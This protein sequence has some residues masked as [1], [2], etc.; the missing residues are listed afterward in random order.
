MFNLYI[1]IARVPQASWGE[2]EAETPV[3]KLCGVALHV[4]PFGEA[5]EDVI[6]EAGW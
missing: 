1:N 2:C 5:S 6:S 3:W 4:F